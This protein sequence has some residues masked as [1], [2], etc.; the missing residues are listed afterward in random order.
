[1]QPQIFVIDTAVVP[2]A[3]VGAIPVTRGGAPAQK[4]DLEGITND[5]EGGFG[6]AS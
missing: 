1:M 5:G 6:L 3:I 2:A 4:L